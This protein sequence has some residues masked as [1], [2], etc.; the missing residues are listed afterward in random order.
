MRNRRESLASKPSGAS[1]RRFRS[2]RAWDSKVI[3]AN[4]STS[5]A[6][7]IDHGFPCLPPSIQQVH[8]FANSLN[9]FA[10]LR[11][12]D[13]AAHYGNAN[14]W[15]PPMPSNV[16][17][18]P[19]RAACSAQRICPKC[20]SPSCHRGYCPGIRF[21]PS[22]AAGVYSVSNLRCSAYGPPRPQR[23]LLKRTARGSTS[24]GQVHPQ[25]SQSKSFAPCGN[26]IPPQA[27]VRRPG[28]GR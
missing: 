2:R 7:A 27:P 28:C 20:P 26:W 8:R 25:A 15:V 21:E 16:N 18:A 10:K 23:L 17:G 9:G 1:S 22:P 5:C 11:R 14:I 19:V 3:F 12:D 4:G 13:S 24:R 6:L